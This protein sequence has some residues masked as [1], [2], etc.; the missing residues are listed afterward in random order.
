ML[1]GARYNATASNFTLPDGSPL[2]Y[3]NWAEGE[4]NLSSGK[5]CTLLQNSTGTWKTVKCADIINNY[6]VCEAVIIRNYTGNN[7]RTIGVDFMLNFNIVWQTFN[8]RHCSH[9]VIARDRLNEKSK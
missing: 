5:E 9:G 3:T 4:P 2:Q 7:M 6:I 1:I 8:W